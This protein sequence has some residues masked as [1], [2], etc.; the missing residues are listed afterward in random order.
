MDRRLFLFAAL[1]AAAATPAFAEGDAGLYDAPPPPNSAFLRIIDARGTT[2]LAATLGDKAVTLTDSAISG[3]AIVPAGTVKIA[4]GEAA[5]DVTIEAGKFY[6]V[7]LFAAGAASP[8]LLED[9]VIANPAKSGVYLYNFGSAEATL[10]AP[11]QKV[12][13]I[14]KVAPGTSGFREINAVTL[15]LE[16]RSGEAV[17]AVPGV[18][19]KRRAGTSFVVFADGKVASTDNA[20]LA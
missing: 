3:Y 7:A 14:E 20:M 8:L 5:G 11:K 1:A 10:F 9:K 18:V 2:G 15:D 16:V 13:V 4:A 17:S 19:L 6:T 12:A